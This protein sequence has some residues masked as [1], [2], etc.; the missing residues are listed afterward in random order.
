MEILISLI[1]LVPFLCFLESYMRKD[2]EDLRNLEVFYK[3]FYDFSPIFVR[4]YITT[5]K[6]EAGS[7]TAAKI[8]FPDYKTGKT[9]A[10]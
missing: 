2:Y 8:K 6:I 4:F 5:T 9:K 10:Y 1:I 7:I 3:D